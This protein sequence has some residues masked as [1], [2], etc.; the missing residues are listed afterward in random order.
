MRLVPR[1]VPIRFSHPTRC[2]RRDES[3]HHNSTVVTSFNLVFL[4]RPLCRLSGC[5][6][7][8][9]PPK[10]ANCC[11]TASV[12]RPVW[13]PKIKDVPTE[14][15]TPAYLTSP[16]A[17]IPIDVG[18]QLFVDDFLIEKT[19]L[20]RTHHRPTYHPKNPVLTGGMVFSDG[21]FYDPQDKH[22]K[23]WYLAKGGTAYATSKDGLTWEKPQ[24]D[25][26]KGTEPR[27]DQSAR[28]QHGLARPGGERPEEALQ[29]VPLLQPAGA[30]IVVSVGPL[31]GGRHS[32]DGAGADRGVRRSDDGVLQPV[33]QGVGL[34]SAARLG[35]TATAALLGGPRRRGEGRSVGCELGAAVVVRL[36]QTRPAARRL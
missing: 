19:T 24:L 2:S 17:V 36:R 22:F 16:P 29:D 3:C 7:R 5:F 13:P 26:M 6:R 8:F 10:K 31:F 9:E 14:P 1:R 33:P 35:P 21:V 18:R 12:Y 25:V 27:A 20:T 30:E 32:L 34:Q 4:E 23:M 11:T 15:V 28:F